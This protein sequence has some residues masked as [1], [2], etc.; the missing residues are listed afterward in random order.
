MNNITPIHTAL[1]RRKVVKGSNFSCRPEK[2]SNQQTSIIPP[3]YRIILLEKVLTY[4]L[5]RLNSA[6]D[7]VYPLNTNQSFWQQFNPEQRA[8]I[9]EQQIRNTRQYKWKPEE[10]N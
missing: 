6:C 4:A 5:D 8:K 2:F 7:S 3:F 10:L 9:L 1:S